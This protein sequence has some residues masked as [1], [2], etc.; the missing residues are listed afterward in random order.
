LFVPESLRLRDIPLRHR[1]RHQAIQRLRSTLL[2]AE[3][4]VERRA[5]VKAIP[6]LSTLPLGAVGTIETV[7]TPPIGGDP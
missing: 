6:A 2:I 1:Q 3:F 5:L 7:S 4:L